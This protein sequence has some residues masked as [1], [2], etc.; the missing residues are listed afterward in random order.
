MY[1]CKGFSICMIKYSICEKKDFHNFLWD[2]TIIFVAPI[3]WSINLHVLPE[4]TICVVEGITK[5]INY[6]AKALA[7]F[8]L[9][10]GVLLLCFCAF[11]CEQERERRAP[12]KFLR[13]SCTHQQDFSLTCS[14]CR[15]GMGFVNT[16][17]GSILDMRALLSLEGNY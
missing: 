10:D 3:Q 4:T 1:I 9:V 11:V 17:A 7:C 13:F 5:H 15:I 2:K 16:R 14:R 6:I 12:Q 8:P